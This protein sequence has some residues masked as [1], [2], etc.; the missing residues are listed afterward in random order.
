[1]P[2]FAATSGF[3]LT[4]FFLY[5]ACGA[6]TISRSD[7]APQSGVQKSF[8]NRCFFR[9]L[10]SSIKYTALLHE[11]CRAVVN[12]I[13][14]KTNKFYTGTKLGNQIGFLLRQGFSKIMLHLVGNYQ[15]MSQKRNFLHQKVQV[16]LTKLPFHHISQKKV[17][18]PIVDF[19]LV[20][21][22]SLKPFP[23]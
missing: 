3:M 21:I 10:I 12:A 19:A 23:P 20:K 17:A 7:I 22:A 2:Y 15:F 6:G 4:I 9:G 8:L 1:M 18:L 14:N 5:V 13:A 11:W 16:Y